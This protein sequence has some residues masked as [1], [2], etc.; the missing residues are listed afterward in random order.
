MEDEE[1]LFMQLSILQSEGLLDNSPEVFASLS[2][3]DAPLA[4]RLQARL[5]RNQLLLNTPKGISQVVGQEANKGLNSL[6]GTVQR[7]Y[8][9]FTSSPPAPT[10]MIGRP[11]GLPQEAAPLDFSLQAIQDQLDPEAAA[12]RQLQELQTREALAQTPGAFP[13]SMGI[14][15]DAA[16]QYNPLLGEGLDTMAL[17]Q[18]AAVEGN[19]SIAERVALLDARGLVKGDLLAQQQAFAAAQGQDASLAV[20]RLNLQRTLQNLQLQ[21]TPQVADYLGAA[22]QG[23]QMPAI[24]SQPANVLQ[25]LQLTQQVA[26]EVQLPSLLPAARTNVNQRLA[27]NSIEQSATLAQRKQQEK[28]LELAFQDFRQNIARPLLSARR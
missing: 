20:D 18:Q 12:R 19:T 21:Q 16:A 10:D 11:G 5:R 4:E 1:Q 9:S 15:Q 25:N 26:P 7:G 22:A 17:Q 2:A 3:R 24:G 28:A 27:S 14:Q 6:I 23:A 8:D 13:E